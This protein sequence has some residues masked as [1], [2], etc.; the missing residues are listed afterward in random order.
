MKVII[1]PRDNVVTKGGE[2]RPI[3]TASLPQSVLSVTFDTVTNTGTVNHEDGSAVAITSLAPYAVVLAAY[4]AWKP[5]EE[6]A[7]VVA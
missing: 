6:A 7:P 2:A 1:S 4:D 3:N 5:A